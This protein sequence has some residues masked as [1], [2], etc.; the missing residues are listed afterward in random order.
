MAAVMAGLGLLASCAGSLGPLKPAWQQDPNLYHH[1]V[2]ARPSQSATTP[3]LV[4][5]VIYAAPDQIIRLIERQ[6]DVPDTQR[7]F[8]RMGDGTVD[9]ALQDVATGKW[10]ESHLCG[11]ILFVSGLPN[12]AYRIVL[13][14]RSPMPLEL[15][16]GVDGKNVTTG[17]AATLKRGGL[18]LEPRGTL[19]LDHSTHGPL[20]FKAVKGDGVLFDSSPQGRSG[21]IRIAV[22]LAADAPSAGPE[23]MR[24]SQIAPLGLL[25]VGAPEQYR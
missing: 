25:P 16:V 3:H 11:G 6:G 17:A 9:L 7:G 23:K 20:L 5:R 8:A 12:Q 18:R 21:L 13:K 19:T 4:V 2:P 1:G 10:L 22:F 15:G 24:P 14:N